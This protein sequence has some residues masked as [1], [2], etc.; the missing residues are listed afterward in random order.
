M[1][2][3]AFYA[4]VSYTHSNKGDGMRESLRMR[5]RPVIDVNQ[6][7]DRIEKVRQLLLRLEYEG[8]NR[9]AIHTWKIVMARLQCEWADVCVEIATKGEYIFE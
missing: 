9:D 3:L 8:G 7:S 4:K 2:L 5:N 1:F 6:L